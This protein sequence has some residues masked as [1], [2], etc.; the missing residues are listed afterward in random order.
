[1]VNNYA[2]RILDSVGE[3]SLKYIEIAENYKPPIKKT[4]RMPKM[5]AAVIAAAMLMGTLTVAAVYSSDIQGFFEKYW[6]SVTG[7][8]MSEEQSM[9][10]G[11][12]SQP[13]NQSHTVGD[14]TVT[15]DSALVGENGFT[16]L[17]C[18]EGQK[19][20]N[21][22]SYSFD[23]IALQVSP[24]VG[25]EWQMSS[26]GCQSHGVSKDK[27]K[28]QILFDYSGALPDTAEISLTLTDFVRSPH[29]EPKIL[30]KGEW[31]FDFTLDCSKEIE[32]I[33]L[34]DTVITAMDIETKKYTSISVENIRITTTGIS[35][36]CDGRSGVF[37]D[38]TLILKNGEEVFQGSGMGNITED[39]RL[40]AVYQWVIPVNLSDIEYLR[41]GETVIYVVE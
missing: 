23:D 32:A 20:S 36:I 33:T 10:I 34:P 39:D 26:F 31:H 30:C 6:Q 18:I 7:E 4:K 19:F 14:I 17:V 35:Y 3:I 9:L 5:A 38:P 29:R 2:D 11:S 22:Y 37:L 25:D 41:L 15:V 24:N 16:L 8:K 12:L 1:M 40:D 27:S 13:I 21:R 28:I